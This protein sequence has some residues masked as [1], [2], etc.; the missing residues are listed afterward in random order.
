MVSDTPHPLLFSFACWFWH[1][2][3]I[4]TQNIHA[5]AA[6]NTIALLFFLHTLFRVHANY[7][8]SMRN[9]GSVFRMY[10]ISLQKYFGFKLAKEEGGE[11]SPNESA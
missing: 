3:T 7:I 11:N 1:Y 5:F 4:H 2:S 9:F 10:T 6:G 8:G